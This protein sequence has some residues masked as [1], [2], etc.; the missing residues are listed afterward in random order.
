M[1][2]TCFWICADLMALV[3]GRVHTLVPGADPVVANVVIEA[4]RIVSIGTEIPE[5]ATLIDVAG[6]DIVPGL[7][8]GFAYHDASHDTLYTIHGV[9]LVRDHGNDLGRILTQRERH[10]R[11]RRAGPDLSIAG[12][13]LDGNPP[14]TTEALVL[15]SPNEVDL[16]LPNLFEAPV[17][18]LATQPGLAPDVL[19][20]VVALGREQ[21][22]ATWASLPAG[23]PLDEAARMGL[24]GIV[25]LDA[26][27]PAGRS[28]LDIELTELD[29]LIALIAELDV[30]VTPLLWGA[31][32][33][34][35]DPS[36]QERWFEVL[37][38][39]YEALWRNEWLQRSSIYDDAYK[40]AGEQVVV[41]QRELLSRLVAAGVAVV[42]GSGAPH[43]WLVPGA[44]LHAELQH[45]VAAGLEPGAVLAAATRDAA[46]TLELAG[47]GT[48]EPG[49]VADL[50][51]VTG[52][53]TVD[54]GVLER[55]Q[56]VVLRGSYYDARDLE[57]MYRTLVNDRSRERE[58]VALPLEIPEPE[59]PEGSLVLTGRSEIHSAAGRLSGERWAVVRTPNGRT[60]FCTRGKT[61]EGTEFTLRQVLA[62]RDLESFRFLMRVGASEFEAL[63]NRVA[64]RMRIQ[65][66]IDGAHISTDSLP[67]PV[68]AVDI[69]SAT[70]LMMLA[71]AREPGRPDDPEGSFSVV[72]FHEGLEI[73]IAE[74]KLELDE[75]GQHMFLTPLGPRAATFTANGALADLVQR[76]GNAFTRAFVTEVE[77]FGGPGLPRLRPES[78]GSGDKPSGR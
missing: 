67:E 54:I 28:W 8:D 26:F 51:C 1:I 44:A 14:T 16:A 56:A 61:A 47:R 30:A 72:R 36:A 17:D 23:L 71:H 66:R 13:V 55:P 68:E 53:P 74:W 38:S 40:A 10:E 76:Q 65:R 45:W 48:L 50:L 57:D 78:P 6:L 9:T 43:P 29:P 64:G 41:K 27:V 52:D 3:G 19:R 32:R 12:A 59:V 31:A 18:F 35:E 37:G 22:L 39:Q 20:R 25:F 70:S 77:T 42:P 15:V 75:N 46:R 60:A 5:G 4:D 63:G 49:H 34:L 11:D 7:I 2:A 62:G 58:T 73:E 24:S 21:G 33:R 69:G